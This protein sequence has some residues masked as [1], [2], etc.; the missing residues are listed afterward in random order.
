MYKDNSARDLMSVNREFKLGKM[1]GTK[2]VDGK[3]VE[4]YIPRKC[5]A[6]SKI[7]GPS[8]SASVQIIVP[9]VDGV[10]RVIQGQ[11]D[12]FAISGFLRTKGRGEWELEKLLRSRGIYP[13]PEDL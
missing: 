7:I 11:E 9:R 4:L 8:D 13:I 5:S 2:N 6:T 1:T 10:G 12:V 3:N